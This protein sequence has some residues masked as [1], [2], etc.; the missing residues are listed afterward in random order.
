MI[1]PVPTHLR[2]A[3]YRRRQGQ[4]GHGEGYQYSHDA[5]DGIAAQ[6]YLGVD[7]SYYHPVNRGM[8]AELQIRLQEIKQRL[9]GDVA[10]IAEDD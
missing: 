8:E 5:D 2:D 9:E 4:L 7:R 1:L 6:D 3:H 10:S